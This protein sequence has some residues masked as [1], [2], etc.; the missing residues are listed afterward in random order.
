MVNAIDWH[1]HREQ[2]SQKYDYR[3][4]DI[5]RSRAWTAYGQESYWQG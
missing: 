1:R 4:C 3:T 5:T 2:T